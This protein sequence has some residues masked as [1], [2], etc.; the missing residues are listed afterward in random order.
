MNDAEIRLAVKLD[1]TESEKKI[2]TLGDKAKKLGDSFTNAGKKL[3]VGLTLP[4]T[5][6]GVYAVKS[7]SD[8]EETMN[9][10]NVAFGDSAE[11]V[12]EWA[13]TSIKSFG[14][15]QQTALD[16][17]ALFGD[18]ATGMGMPQKEA[19]KLSRNLTGLAGD[20][21][22]FKNVSQDVAKTALQGIFTGE[23]ESL[24]QMGIVMTQTNLEQFALANGM[25]SNMQTMTE[26]EKIQLRYAYVTNASKNAIGDFARTSDST[27]NQVRTAGETYK[28]MSATFGELLLPIVNKVLGKITELFTWFTSLDDGTKGFILTVLGVVAAAGPLLL[29]LGQLISFITLVSKATWLFNGALL[30]NPITWVVIGIVALIAI[31]VLLIK[32]FDKVK[33]V[34]S[35]VGN[36]MMSVFRGVGD[37]IG[38]IFKGIA[39]TI[40]G[41]LNIVTRALNGLFAGILSPINAF[42]RALNKI[43]G[44]RIAEVKME[45]PK[46]PALATGT[47]NVQRDG[48]A[49]LHQGEAVVPKKYNPAMGG[50]Q[51]ITI[52][53]PD[54]YMDNERVGRAV[55]PSI[56]R[57][58]RLAGAR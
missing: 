32:N 40:I 48:L 4:I 37:V 29:V 54:I 51:T 53:M 58:L 16:M 39:N 25:K 1:S 24:K 23:T 55:T 49:F 43:P 19:S 10:V 44:T 28:E 20:L 56:T 52:E 46:I 5:G 14:M 27:A 50:M 18:M 45:I 34:A 9:K 47:N 12:K 15:A 31:I 11:E 22:S 57:T 3:T 30:A 42:I 35:A 21:A 8:L 13:K 7:A 2:D 26:A 36:F 38:S 41:V 6:L 17:T 33:V